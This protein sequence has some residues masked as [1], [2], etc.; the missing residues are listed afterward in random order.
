MA[1]FCSWA[2][3]N[4]S[5]DSGFNIVPGSTQLLTSIQQYQRNL[6]LQAAGFTSAQIQTLGGGP[7]RYL[8]TTGLSYIGLTRYD[9]GPFVQ[10]D[11][12]IHPNLTLS[13]G[14]RYE[15]QTLDSDHRDWAPRVGF[16][17][18]PGTSKNGP[19]K[20]VIRGGAGI[21]YDRVPLSMFESAALQ[22]GVAQ[23]SY[24][25]YNP[26]FY[27]SN[28]PSPST[29]SPG[30]NTTYIVDPKYRADYSIQSASVSRGSYRETPRHP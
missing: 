27:L 29:L 10:D 5:W 18:A 16:A 2:G 28:I 3:W 21:F 25:V 7:S 26:N 20:T 8:V 19:Q 14:L 24:T 6:Q 4:R 30:Q 22:N 13:L 11:W 23:R 1:S 17:W 9:A 15:V 12:K